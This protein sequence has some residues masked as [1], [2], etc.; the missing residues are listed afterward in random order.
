MGILARQKDAVLEVGGFRFLFFFWDPRG[1]KK[2]RLIFFG[3]HC[4]AKH[5]SIFFSLKKVMISQ[6][7]SV[8]KSTGHNIHSM[9]PK[10][11]NCSECHGT[12]TGAT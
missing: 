9:H 8:C 3:L 2:L 12:M 11:R 10:L 7:F 5:E 6:C 1:R 4:F